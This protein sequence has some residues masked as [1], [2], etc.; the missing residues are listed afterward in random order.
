MDFD[1]T[2]PPSVPRDAA[3]VILVRARP[4]DDAPEVFLVRRTAKAS[5]MARAF[6]FPG[7]AKDG[8]EDLRLT[9]TRELLEEAGVLVADRAVAPAKVA[10][11][12]A[13]L[14][15]GEKLEALLA[16][17]G[18]G[19][20]PLPLV[21]HWITPSAEKRRFSAR[22]F[23]AELPPGQEPAIDGS[24][25]VEA[26]WASPADALERAGE[27]A[28]PPPQLRTLWDLREARTASELAALARRREPQ[29]VPVV[30]RFCL[31]PAAPMGFALL[32][33]WD[34]E[35]ATRGQGDGEP[36]PAD[37]PLAGGD[38]RFVLDGEAGW[39]LTR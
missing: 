25:V 2:R 16:E 13:R 1:P 30:P 15:A 26:R 18:A 21:A 7:G 5:F 37:H 33:P 29:V 4:G 36:L 17:V 38:S 39:R 24:E 11:L 31:E 8:D 28:L 34:P 20:A 14:A 12:R 23:L 3:A 35:Y 10:E 32:L 27:L 22:F 9:A 19:L 6:V